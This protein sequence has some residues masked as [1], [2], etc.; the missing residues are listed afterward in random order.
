MQCTTQ[1]LRQLPP[2]SIGIPCPCCLAACHSPVSVHGFTLFVQVACQAE[3]R[4]LRRGLARARQEDEDVVQLRKIN[5][6]EWRNESQSHVHE[7]PRM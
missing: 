6:G 5:E 2:P 4:D 1:A 3:V 7:A